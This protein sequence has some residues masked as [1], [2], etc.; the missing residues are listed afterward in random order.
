MKD[1]TVTIGYESFQI[2]KNN[3]D[4]YKELVHTNKDA[5]K[6]IQ[7]FNETLC[8]VI[9]KANEQK[10]AAN[11]QFF[12]AEGIKAICQYYDMDLSTEFG[13]LDEGEEPEKTNIFA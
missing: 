4:K 9:E 12:I 7:E 5:L 11:K 6:K 10:I 2:I 1:A 3:A 13:E 8:G